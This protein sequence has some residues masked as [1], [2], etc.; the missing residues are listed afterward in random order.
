MKAN[1]RAQLS[2]HTFDRHKQKR[3]QSHSS[4]DKGNFDLPPVYQD[5]QLEQRQHLFSHDHRQFGPWQQA[6]MRDCSGKQ[7]LF[8]VFKVICIHFFFL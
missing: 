6:P 3:G 2:R 4:A 5:F 8:D 7:S 1:D